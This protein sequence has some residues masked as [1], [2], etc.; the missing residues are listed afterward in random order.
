MLCLE[1]VKIFLVIFQ[2]LA[3]ANGSAALFL[4]L[5]SCKMLI[6]DFCPIFSVV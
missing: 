2:I 6:L 4:S 3:L 1:A 5:N